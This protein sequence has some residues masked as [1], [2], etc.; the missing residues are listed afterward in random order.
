MVLDTR[1]LSKLAGAALRPSGNA[2]S[3]TNHQW[4]VRPGPARLVVR[5]R[6]KITNEAG[7][8]E[9][10][11]CDVRPE[12]T[13][14]SEG[15]VDGLDVHTTVRSLEADHP[16]RPDGYWTA[17]VVKPRGS[18]RIEIEIEVAVKPGGAA[19]G[20]GLADLYAISVQVAISTYGGEGLRPRVH[21]VILPLR[22]APPTPGAWREVAPGLSVLPILTHLLTPADDAVAV[23]R[24]Y[25]G[26][27]AEPGDIVT[28]GES[29]LAIMQG[30]FRH[31]GDIKTTVLARRLC[32]LLSGVGSLGT[33]PG[34]QALIDEVGLGPVLWGLTRG[35]WGKLR[36]RDGDFYRTVGDPARLLDDV[37]GT[38]A[39][40]D[41]Y[42]VLGP[43][44]PASE[45]A[46]IRKETG[47]E[48]AVVDV[49]DLGAV[50][51]LAATPGCHP[52]VVRQALRS[53]P[54]GNGA[55]TTPVVL[56]RRSLT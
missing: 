54:A 46:R 38:L 3:F 12:V 7:D 56:I 8:R 17:Y 9:V 37:T 36:G 4:E 48:A 19:E 20:A 43:A 2:V 13:L 51:V 11:V 47:L 42:L 10:M 45:V 6:V 50:D 16:S 35:T 44:E 40:Y 39:P 24:R 5:G 22:W 23:I 27:R 32:Y 30:R 18:R 31:P 25:A 53:N 14:L 55:E 52:D 34:L 29:P 21:P 26:G 33:A 41:Q 15:P 1:T 28:I 49:N